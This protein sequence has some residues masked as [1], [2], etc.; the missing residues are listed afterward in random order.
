MISVSDKLKQLDDLFTRDEIMAC[1][2]SMNIFGKYKNMYPVEFNKNDDHYGIIY[3]KPKIPYNLTKEMLDNPCK[4][5]ISLLF[6]VDT[7]GISELFTELVDGDLTN[8]FANSRISIKKFIVSDIPIA[9]YITLLIYSGMSKYRDFNILTNL[10]ESDQFHKTYQYLSLYSL[11]SD[12]PYDNPKNYH[13]L[14][15]T[16]LDFETISLFIHIRRDVK[17]CLES[18]YAEQRRLDDLDELE[19]FLRNCGIFY[20]ENACN[21]FQNIN[22]LLHATDEQLVTALGRLKA[23]R[24]IRFLRGNNA[25]SINVPP[26]I[27]ESSKHMDL[28]VSLANKNSK[29]EPNDDTQL[30]EEPEQISHICTICSD[31]KINILLLPCRHTFCKRCII[32]WIKKSTISPSC[33]LCRTSIAAQV[34]M[35]V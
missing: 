8:I 32:N 33:P 28:A 4:L 1:K 11:E 14:F 22:N 21:Y 25:T 31:K 20:T 24:M 29:Q 19:N 27:G 10:L 7:R 13:K 6:I 26:V 34:E 23:M 12:K 30:I 2:S 16:P 18:V 15:P 9:R 17:R 5:L 35:I 3:G